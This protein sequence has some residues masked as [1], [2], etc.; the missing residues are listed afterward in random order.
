M[1]GGD[2]TGPMGQGPMTGWG[3]GFC[4][5]F[6]RAG[7]PNRG[8]GRGYGRGLGWRNRFCRRIFPGWG[9]GRNVPAPLT[10]QDELNLLKEQAEQLQQDL[11]QVKQRMDVL[12][13]EK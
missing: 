6:G 13:S 12:Q 1:P 8:Y 10:D 2:G 7:N 11:Q 5:G 3:A 4:G 9:F